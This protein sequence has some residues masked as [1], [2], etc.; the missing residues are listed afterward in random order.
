[1]KKLS[2]LLVM[3]MATF[4]IQAQVAINKDG[5]APNAGSILHVKGSSNIPFYIE[6]ATGEVG[7]NTTSP[8]GALH[9]KMLG[10]NFSQGLHI[11]SNTSTED[12]YLYMN[13][14]DNLNLRN[15]AAELLT[16]TKDNGFLGLGTTTP[17]QKLDV[18]G[19]GTFLG[20]IDAS[21]DITSGADI[22][23][24]GDLWGTNG[25]LTDNLE[26][27]SNVAINTSIV[28]GQQLA[29]DGGSNIGINV[30]NS[31]ATYA[32]L[33]VQNA[34][35]GPSIF[36]W[37]GDI[38]L[39]NGSSVDIN[40]AGEVNRAA[41]GT[42]DLIP[43]AYGTVQYDAT[44]LDAGTGNWSAAWNGTNE[45]MEITITGENYYY[46]Y[47]TTIVTPIG[48]SSARMGTTSSANNKLLVTMWTS[49][50]AKDSNGNSF[51]FVVYKH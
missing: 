44:I 51:S 34:G 48:A 50:G 40:G 19:N 43:I 4:A 45:R 39:R 7:I 3:I 16:I 9:I 38:E 42:A 24:N 5:S 14:S 10:T 12:W 13:G 22:T 32:A 37:S 27:G 30:E 11:Q 29:V 6:D 28:S 20:T 25:Y 33:R 1:M 47:Y 18:V 17:T 46:Q 2:I 8:T 21:G 36:V 15:D 41:Q 31:N 26:V 35:G 23:A 49:S